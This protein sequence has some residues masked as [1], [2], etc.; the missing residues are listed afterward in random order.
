MR[1]FDIFFSAL[2]I[3]ALSPLLVITATVLKATGEGEV[4]FKQERI[5]RNG[6]V[7]ALLKF[8]TM[9][10][11]SPNI[12]TGTLTLKDDPRILPFG[13]FLRAAKINELPQL[14]NVFVGHM[15]I[16]GP[17]PQTRRCF[18]AFPEK[19]QAAILEVRPGLSGIG[20][21]VFRSEDELT[22]KSANPVYF[23]DHVI[24]P[25]KGELEEWYV[26]NQSAATYFACIFL[27]FWVVIFPDTKLHW[28]VLRGLPRPSGELAELKD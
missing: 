21:I 20:S 1:A 19:S 18:E 22:R 26:T 10:K 11:D 24:M 27:T 28:R 14:L 25:Y 16:V 23:Y 5:G 7:F 8:V 2:A 17:R 3:V 6:N 12:G 4:L 13:K 9:V 15:S